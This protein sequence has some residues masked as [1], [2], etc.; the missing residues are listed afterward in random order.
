MFKKK[1][2]YKKRST[3]LPFVIFRWL[4]SLF[5]FTLL[6]GGSYSAYKHFS[7]V[8]PLKIDPKALVETTV[9]SI[10][11]SSETTKILD[12][13]FGFSLKKTKETVIP[14]DSNNNQSQKTPVKKSPVDFRFI[15]VADS[16][17]KNEL[18]KE[19]LQQGQKKYTDVKFIIGL[20]DYTEVGT[21]GELEAA[22]QV[23]DGSGLRYFVTAGDHDL[24]DSRNRQLTPTDNFVKVFGPPY[25]SFSYGQVRFVIFNNSDNYEGLGTQQLSWLKEE[26][27]RIKQEKDTKLILAFSQ[28]PLYHPSSL[29]TM[30]RV[31]PALKSEAQQ[32]INWFK[33]VGVKG[34]FAGD[35]H[36]FTSYKEPSSGM[37]M[38]TI[39]AI[40]SEPNAQDPRYSVVTIYQDGSFSVDDVAINQ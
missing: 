34:V 10:V 8:D 28:E 22:K 3:P 20:G 17:N 23:F 1:K 39:G 26:L 12:Q 14:A 35:I 2:V 36:Y 25:Q 37:A 9:V 16:H 15:L 19:A 21:M 31:T 18:L 5:I 40:T 30:G 32:I 11:N 29:H 7:G 27:D 33:D 6:V 13:I 24:W 38:F 4:L